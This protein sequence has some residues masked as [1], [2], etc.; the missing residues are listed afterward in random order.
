MEVFAP[1]EESKSTR[2]ALEGDKSANRPHLE[3]GKKELDFERNDKLTQITP[4]SQSGE[5]LPISPQVSPIAKL[6]F[7]FEETF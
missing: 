5:K 3:G 1:E 2:F 4:P 7:D 6:N